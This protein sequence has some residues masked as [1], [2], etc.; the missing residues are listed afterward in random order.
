[1]KQRRQH[2][3]ER[4]R[5]A[6]AAS[7]AE[8][9][10][11]IL[12]PVTASWREGAARQLARHGGNR[13]FMKTTYDLQFIGFTVAFVEID[14]DNPAAAQNMREAV[15]FWVGFEEALERSD[16]DYAVRFLKNLTRFIVRNGRAPED[17]E[18]WPAMNGDA[19]TG[20]YINFVDPYPVDDDDIEIIPI[21]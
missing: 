17:E 8:L 1:M 19:D 11:R 7:H 10:R 2:I 5:R 20:I 12:G 4:Q 6:L 13:I 14:H 15:E 21:T 3:R 18:G 9:M 16:G